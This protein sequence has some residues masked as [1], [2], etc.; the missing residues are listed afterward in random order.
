VEEQIAAGASHV[1][2]DFPD[3]EAALNRFASVALAA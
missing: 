3:L 1:A 2:T